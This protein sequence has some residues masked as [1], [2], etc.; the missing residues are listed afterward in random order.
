MA[1]G[2]VQQPVVSQQLPVLTG[3]PVSGM[4][5]LDRPLEAGYFIFPDLSVRH[6]GMYRLSFNLYEEMR[7]PEEISEAQSDS[8]RSISGLGQPD[9]SF[10]WR[11]EVKSQEFMVFSAKKFPGLAESTL[12]SRTVSEQGCRVRIRRDIRMRRR[13]G[14]GAEFEEPDA[15]RGRPS[16]QEERERSRS[17]SDSPTRGG[18]PYT[19]EQG[20]QYPESPSYQESP[21]S[22]PA[23]RPGNYLQF[24]QQVS[25]PQPQFAQPP[26][27][28]LPYQSQPQSSFRGPPIQA[29]QHP[30]IYHDRQQ[31]QPAYASNSP[32]EREEFTPEFKRASSIAAYQPPPP[33]HM[34][35]MERKYSRDAYVPYG[36]RPIS[37]KLSTRLPP[38]QLSEPKP[39][40]PLSPFAAIRT[41]G[42]PLPISRAR[43]VYRPSFPTLAP[44]APIAAVDPVREITRNGKRTHDAVFRPD[45]NHPLRDG[46]RPGS[47]P[48]NVDDEDEYDADSMGPPME[49]R[50]ASGNVTQ[51]DA[52]IPT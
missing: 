42:P 21:V 3:M 14:K 50:R 25:A 12:L 33:P 18:A 29:P 7:D 43:D 49:Y 8:K 36:G 30:K 15:Y 2:R 31:P 24:G 5:Y 26:P 6:E 47:I 39:Q 38:L 48:S 34:P 11:M 9:S 20:R 45:D 1:H 4:A 32:H 46:A 17:L 10:D 35:P 51:R 44:L 40:R 27:P 13:D 16:E 23:P 22:G 41:D 28:L 52:N 37:P 19:D